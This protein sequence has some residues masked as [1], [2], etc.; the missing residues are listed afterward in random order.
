LPI[1]ISCA[2]NSPGFFETYTGALFYLDA[3]AW[4][5]LGARD[6]AADL[7]RTRLSRPQSGLVMI[8]LMA[9][10]LAILEGR[11]EEAIE[12]MVSAAFD[13]EP[14]VAFYLARH[15]SMLDAAG[16]TLKMLARARCGG[17][18]SSSTLQT[19]A[20]FAGI[21]ELPAFQQEI[22]EAKCREAQ[23]ELELQDSL[24]FVL[25]PRGA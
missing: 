23:A 24:G 6:R 11:K 25:V 8:T 17:F 21:R 15:C 10:L 2:A 22:R 3:A 20:V 9:S 19:D 14:E 12:T 16:P 5:A 4:A 1:L 18:W 7:L 13:R